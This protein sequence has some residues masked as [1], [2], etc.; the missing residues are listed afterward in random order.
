MCAGRLAQ[1][2]TTG[3]PCAVP[4]LERRVLSA[5]KMK[6]K[7]FPPEG[8]CDCNEVHQGG[9]LE[10]RSPYTYL[11]IPEGI[12]R[13]G[14]IENA[15]RWITIAPEN[16]LC[17]PVKVLCQLWWLNQIC[18]PVPEWAVIYIII[19]LFALVHYRRCSYVELGQM[20]LSQR[21]STPELTEDSFIDARCTAV[22]TCE[23][24]LRVTFP[25][26]AWH[27]SNTFSSL[28]TSSLPKAPS[29]MT[30]EMMK[31]SRVSKNGDQGSDFKG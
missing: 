21:Q 5:Y 25:L 8:I 4:K 9:G 12:C 28:S 26:P 1:R 7:G 14:F 13:P 19:Q 17:I 22:C 23:K 11:Y 29:R 30:S 10:H 3:Y 6:Q 16:L 20:S 31:S 18:C 24:F 15:N 27:K 2:A